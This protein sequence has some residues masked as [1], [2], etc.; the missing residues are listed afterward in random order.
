MSSQSL[1]IEA[2]YVSFTTDGLFQI[3]NLNSDQH[4]WEY[5]CTTYLP[6][7]VAQ[8][9]EPQPTERSMVRIQSSAQIDNE[10]LQSTVLKRQRLRKRRPGLVHF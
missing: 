1:S 6:V 9:V 8:L 5:H 10:R 4:C 2:D 3:E 7:V